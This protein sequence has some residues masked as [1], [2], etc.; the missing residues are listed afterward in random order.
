[1]M[2][3]CDRLRTTMYR[4]ETG[5]QQSICTARE[6]T[7]RM[8]I[9]WVGSKPEEGEGLGQSQRREKAKPGPKPEE[10]EG[11]GQSQRREKAWAKA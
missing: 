8:L 2:E 1:M 3:D 10:G 9:G 6:T 5:R 11:L 7:G 4:L